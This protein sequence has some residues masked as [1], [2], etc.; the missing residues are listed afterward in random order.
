MFIPILYSSIFE[1]MNTFLSEKPQAL[2]LIEMVEKGMIIHDRPETWVDAPNSFLDV[3]LLYLTRFIFFFNPYAES[4]S[5]IHNVLN[6][7]QTLII[8]FSIFILIFF[9]SNAKSIEK[10]L[11][12]ILIT[13]FSV[14][15]FHSFTLI[16]YDWRYRFP[17]IIPLIM[18]LPMSLEIL[19]RNINKNVN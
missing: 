14:A 4:F 1:F 12:L 17:I 16:D 8:V 9:K 3:A 2:F 18:I 10:S 7:F 6:L 13:S 15:F 19:L 5:I 11:V